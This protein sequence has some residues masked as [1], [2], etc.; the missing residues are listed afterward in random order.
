MEKD[1]PYIF[2]HHIVREALK[3]EPYVLD[4]LPY[5]EGKKIEGLWV[6]RSDSHP[7]KG[8]DAIVVK[9]VSDYLRSRNLIKIKND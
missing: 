5:L 7:N 1:Y 4:L 8:A 6:T 3:D 9:A 2:Y